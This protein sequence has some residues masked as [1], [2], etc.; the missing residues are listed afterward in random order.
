MKLGS[1]FGGLL[2]AFTMVWASLAGAR[3]ADHLA[4][5]F[6]YEIEPGRKLFLQWQKPSVAGKPTFLLLPGIN[7]SIFMLEEYV[8]NILKK[9]YGVVTFNFSA[10][11]LSSSLL[12]KEQK[13]YFVDHDY[14]LSD[15]A[16]EVEFLAEYLRG[17]GVT[18]II[19]VT[20]SFTGALSPYLTSF[21][22][23]IDMSPMTSM[24]AHNPTA[25]MYRKSLDWN[26]FLSK[27][28]KRKMIDDSYRSFWRP[29][30]KSYIT[31]Y[32]LPKERESNMIEGL[33]E[34]SRAGEDSDWFKTLPKPSGRHVF[35]IAGKESSSLLR[36]QLQTTEA[37]T[38]EID[39][40]VYIMEGAG[41]LIWDTQA[42]A[43]AD[44]LDR[45]AANADAP[46]TLVV[47]TAKDGSHALTRMDD[48]RECERYLRSLPK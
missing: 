21:P 4:G 26:F 34:M 47:K 17:E 44:V 31:D 12:D 18:D 41:H 24:A 33:V 39:T 36:H 7:R 37:Y 22:L 43:L 25:D 19:P 10:H 16:Y 35:I 45:I 2:L 46:G 32:K 6:P 8:Q 29:L 20:L 11:P 48:A 3:G 23:I 40:Q 13:P 14:K 1:F 5:I 15:L 28:T 27:E 38:K 42:S 9:G 30:A